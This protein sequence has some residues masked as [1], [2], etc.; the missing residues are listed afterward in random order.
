M[1]GGHWDQALYTA[2]IWILPL[3]LAITLH[4]AAHGYAALRLGDDT[5]LREGR[6]SLNPLRH[7]DP[8]GTVLIPALLLISSAPFLF[9]YAKP[10]PVNFSRLN[11][12]RSDMVWVAAAGPA[13]NFAL[14]IISALLMHLIF[15]VPA[16]ATSWVADNLLNSFYINIIIA[17]FNLIPLPPLD[18]GRI[19][20]G[21]LPDWIAMPLARLERFGMMILIGALFLLPYIGRTLGINLNIFPWLIGTPVQ[22]FMKLI[23]TMTG[24][25]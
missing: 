9:G 21:I 22:F 2:S 16:S 25:G 18:G 17:I 12:P 1:M 3:L 5:A 14:A 10:V 4:E 11:R 23:G 6:I 15:L 20:V 19:A 24:H 7:V 8:F 13:T